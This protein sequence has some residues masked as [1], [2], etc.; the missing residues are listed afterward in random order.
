ML[1]RASTNHKNA[2]QRPLGIPFAGFDKIV[3]LRGRS[4]RRAP[5]SMRLCKAQNA[6]VQG[7]ECDCAFTFK[8]YAVALFGI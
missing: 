3:I 6:I 8:T 7:A 5:R 4:F 2:F 1:A